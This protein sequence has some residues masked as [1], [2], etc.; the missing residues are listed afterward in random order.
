MS[1]S[2]NTFLDY[3]I[4]SV[5]FRPRAQPWAGKWLSF[6]CKIPWWWRGGCLYMPGKDVYLSSMAGKGLLSFCFLP[7]AVVYVCLFG[8]LSTAPLAGYFL[9]TFILWLKIFPW[10]L[11]HFCSPGRHSIS[12]LWPPLWYAHARG[13]RDSE[14]WLAHAQSGGA[15]GS[16]TSIVQ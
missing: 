1:T 13:P 7:M 10:H 3:G 4:P 14:A 16:C 12:G 5:R 9:F 8:V 15:P 2:W 6:R 11:E